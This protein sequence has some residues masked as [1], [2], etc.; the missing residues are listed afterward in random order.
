[1]THISVKLF[2]LNV[3]FDHSFHQG[4]VCLGHGS[5]DMYQV[6]LMSSGFCKVLRFPDTFHGFGSCLVLFC[7]LEVFLGAPKVSIFRVAASSCSAGIC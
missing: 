2:L 4:M 3:T 5:R 6:E 1:M 7:V